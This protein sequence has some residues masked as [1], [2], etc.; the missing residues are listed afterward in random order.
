MGGNGRL[1]QLRVPLLKV[2]GLSCD[3]GDAGHPDLE[4][5]GSYGPELRGATVDAAPCG[6][7]PSTLAQRRAV[8]RARAASAQHRPSC[9]QPPVLR[10]LRS[11]E[12][13]CCAM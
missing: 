4:D 2:E 8:L 13:S 7:A 3:L 11:T 5:A 1:W 6:P 12:R 10:S 9:R